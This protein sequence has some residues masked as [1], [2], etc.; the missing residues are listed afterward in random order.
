M[1][2][3]LVSGLHHSAGEIGSYCS[4]TNDRVR[5]ESDGPGPRGAPIGF[6]VGSEHLGR[7][8]PPARSAARQGTGWRGAARPARLRRALITARR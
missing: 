4:K 3:L 7:R 6:G 5:H 2:W 1:G 8:A